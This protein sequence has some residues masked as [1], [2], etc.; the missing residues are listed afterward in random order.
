[1]RVE[2]SSG[3][4]VIL[5]WENDGPGSSPVDVRVH[6]GRFVLHGGDGHPSGSRIFSHDLGH[7]PTGEWTH[8]AVRVRFSAN[9]EKGHVSV[10]RDGRTVVANHHPRGGTLYP[11][12]QSYLKAGLRR[13]AGTSQSASVK[14][15]NWHVSGVHHED[16][17]PSGRSSATSSSRAQH[18]VSGSHSTTSHQSGGGHAGSSGSKHGRS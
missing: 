10:K 9:P 14:L 3:H 15:R 11:G 7:A 13:D 8:L 1:V 6:D 16:S 2:H 17:H 4:H 12:Q 5:R 18:H